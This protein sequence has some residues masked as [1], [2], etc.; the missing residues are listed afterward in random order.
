MRSTM[1][2]GVA[3]AALAMLALS[4]NAEDKK[5]KYAIKEVMQ[6]AHK[7]GLLKTVLSGSAN[8]EQKDSLVEMYIS[9]GQNKPPKGDDKSWKEKTEALLTAAKGVAKGDKEATGKLKKAS[10]CMECHSVHRG[11]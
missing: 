6:K 11:S 1:L 2:W 9:L 3:L 8:K 5:P 7:G 10:N 4:G